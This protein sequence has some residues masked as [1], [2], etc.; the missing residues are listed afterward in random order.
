MQYIPGAIHSSLD[1]LDLTLRKQ[2]ECNEYAPGSD[3]GTRAEV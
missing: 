3:L 2:G 1:L